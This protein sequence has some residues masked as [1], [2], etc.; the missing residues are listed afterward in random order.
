MAEKQQS[1]AIISIKHMIAV[2]S[3][4]RKFAEVL[5]QKTPQFLA[6]ITNVVAENSQLQECD[7]ASIMSAAFVAATYDLPIDNNLGFAAIVPFK[8]KAQFQIMY[9]G[10]VQLAIRSGYYKKINYASVYQDE[11]QSYNPITGEIVFVDDFSKCT[12]RENGKEEKIIGYYARFELA[13]GYV[14]ELFMTKQAMYK[15]AKKYSK[16]YQKDIRENTKKSIWSVNFE[17]M[18]LKTVLKLLLSKWGILS[19]DLQR[20]VLN[21]YNSYDENEFV[22]CIDDKS[23][24][25]SDSEDCGV[26]NV[27]EENQEV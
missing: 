13:T 22:A 3:V 15:H 14:H 26:K 20:A 16:S 17:E 21:E 4:K 8:K 23:Q 2:E 24:D 18:A 7:A 27:F 12:F 10:F 11:L 9:K 1:N 6:S 25:V 19:V 5:G